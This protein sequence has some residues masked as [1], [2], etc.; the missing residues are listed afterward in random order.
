LP[1][2]IASLGRDDLRKPLLHDLGAL[3]AT[4]GDVKE[5]EGATT[6]IDVQAA[7]LYAANDDAGATDAGAS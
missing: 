1:A 7:R 6:D 5:L 4:S 3:L 2:E